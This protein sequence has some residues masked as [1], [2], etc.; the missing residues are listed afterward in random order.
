MVGA[1]GAA[2]GRVIAELRSQVRLADAPR[3]AAMHTRDGG[4]VAVRPAVSHGAR[5]TSGAAALSGGSGRAG[6]RALG[7]AIAGAMLLA[8]SLAPS[9]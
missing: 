6:S 2:G 9:R 5:G 4:R 7:P 8:A 1:T 3:Q